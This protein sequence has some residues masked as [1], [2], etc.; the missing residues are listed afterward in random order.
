MSSE[1]LNLEQQA[2]FYED[3]AKHCEARA[4]TNRATAQRL[5]DAAATIK[6]NNAGRLD[7]SNTVVEGTYLKARVDNARHVRIGP[8][9][10][11]SYKH[12]GFWLE[13]PPYG[14]EW[15]VV[16]DDEHANVLITRPVTTPVA[17]SCTPDDRYSEK[18]TDARLRF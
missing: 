6:R 7:T 11:G 2:A 18:G 5:R 4:E 9:I 15:A 12:R 16:R 13:N 10:G 1:L 8:R 17:P 14:F 3:R